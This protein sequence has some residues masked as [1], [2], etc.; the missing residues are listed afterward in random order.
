MSV[1]P[2][3]IPPETAFCQLRR[4][5]EK[6]GDPQVGTDLHRWGKG[7]ETRALAVSGFLVAFFLASERALEWVSKQLNDFACFSL[8]PDELL[9]Q[10][11]DRCFRG[12][13][14]T[15]LRELVSVKAWYRPQPNSL[16]FADDRQGD[17]SP[18]G[19]LLPRSHLVFKAPLRPGFLSLLPLSSSQPSQ[20]RVAFA[21]P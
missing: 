15:E 13:G 1:G 6:T 12:V 7:P 5:G 16:V 17:G 14:R 20:R 21:I 18:W 3:D 9:P 19:M 4:P 11:P 10:G 8:H 2:T